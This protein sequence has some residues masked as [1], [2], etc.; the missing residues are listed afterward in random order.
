MRRAEAPAGDESENDI[1]LRGSAEPSVET[2]AGTE[3]SEYLQGVRVFYR[4]QI[5]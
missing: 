5:P 4:C 3:G 2:A 1:C